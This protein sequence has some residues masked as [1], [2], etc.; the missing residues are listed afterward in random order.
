[1][2]LARQSLSADY[3][4]TGACIAQASSALRRHVSYMAR[5]LTPIVIVPYSERGYMIHRLRR[6][7]LT[8]VDICGDPVRD[9][10]FGHAAD[11]RTTV[12]KAEESP[13]PAPSKKVAASAPSWLPD[14]VA[15]ICALGYSK[16]RAETV[17]VECD[18]CTS[19]K[20]AVVCALSKLTVN[21]S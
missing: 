10:R 21:P 5:D 17:L 3:V 14:A 1:M 13:A 16:R 8:V 19:V 2:F 4:V 9:L 11:T 12:F 7:G 6:F 18:D 15:A 20:E